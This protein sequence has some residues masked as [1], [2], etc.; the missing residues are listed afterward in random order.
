MG[1]SGIA[2]GRGSVAERA[3]VDN[4]RVADA[5]IC[6]D[7]AFGMAES[8]GAH[9]MPVSTQNR[10]APKNIFWLFRWRPAIARNYLKEK[11]L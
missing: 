6:A 10:G 3:I 5:I 7:A 2:S 4:V 8:A 9:Q 11:G 1:P